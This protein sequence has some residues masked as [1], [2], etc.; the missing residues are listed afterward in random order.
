[1]AE[2]VFS[3]SGT[4]SVAAE[5]VISGMGSRDSSAVWVSDSW[6]K[7]PGFKSLQ[8]WLENCFLHGQLSVLTYFQYVFHPC[9]TAVAC[10]RSQSFC[11]KC[12]WQVTAK[13]TCTL[14][15]WLWMKWHCKVV[16]GWCTHNCQYTTSVDIKNISLKGYSYSFRITC[17]MSA[18]CLLKSRE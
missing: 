18:V 11:Q 14:P 12:R 17:N 16:H 4:Q 8:E 10:T 3:I 5:D 1:M 6:S 9:V 2:V 7:G 15:M 13:H